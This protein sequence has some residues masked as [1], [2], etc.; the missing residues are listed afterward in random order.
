M[1]KLIIILP[2]I[3]LSICAGAQ[4]NWNLTFAPSPSDTNGPGSGQYVFTALPTNPANINAQ[5]P[6]TNAP[7]GSTNVYFSLLQLPGNPCYIFG[8]FATATG[9]SV[10]SGP[11]YFDFSA[12][13]LPPSP[14]P[15]PR[16]PIVIRK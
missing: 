12:W 2:S 11:L 8:A 1:K 5:V 9:T 16:P 6:V 3:I 13:P 14:L 4:T 15:I 10:L 7:A